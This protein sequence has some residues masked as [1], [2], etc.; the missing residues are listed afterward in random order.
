MLLI[1]I[2]FIITLKIFYPTLLLDNLKSNKIC[3]LCNFTCVIHLLGY[4]KH[5]KEHV[6]NKK[7]Y[8]FDKK[9]IFGMKELGLILHFDDLSSDDIECIEQKVGAK[10][11]ALTVDHEKESYIGE[12]PILKSIL[13]YIDSVKHSD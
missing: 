10:I 7:N 9:Q 6:M 8:K 5:R 2:Q 3:N 11:V 13:A 4:N 12:K 1:E